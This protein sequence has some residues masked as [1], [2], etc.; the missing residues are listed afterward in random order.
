[1]GPVL[2]HVLFGTSIGPLDLGAASL[3]GGVP[4]PLGQEDPDPSPQRAQGP[5][6]PGRAGAQNGPPWNPWPAGSGLPSRPSPKL[7][8]LLAPPA[9]LPK[10]ASRPLN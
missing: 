5:G 8:T 1:M 9:T 6:G 2:E 3:F 10:T 7:E 4:G